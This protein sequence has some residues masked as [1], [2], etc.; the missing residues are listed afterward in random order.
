M[1]ECCLCKNNI[2]RKKNFLATRA[3][4]HTH[5]IDLRNYSEYIMTQLNYSLSFNFQI[6]KGNEY[7][8]CELCHI[9]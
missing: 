4:T 8:A 2:K 5:I 1:H 9:I 7:D 6:K 3:H